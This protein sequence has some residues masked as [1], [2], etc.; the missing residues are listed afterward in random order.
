MVT[1]SPHIRT[2]EID[3]TVVILDLEQST[4]SVLNEAASAIWRRVTMTATSGVASSAPPQ[5]DQ[6]Q[7]TAAEFLE[8]CRR[9]RLLTDDPNTSLP[10]TPCTGWA[11]PRSPLALFLIGTTS[12]AIARGHFHTLYRRIALK[13]PAP[14]M[15]VDLNAAIRSFLVA[16]HFFPSSPDD[17]LPRSLSL[18]RYLTCLGVP[19]V[20]KIGVTLTPFTAHA[21]VEVGDAV[22]L[23]SPAF[24][25]LSLSN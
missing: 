14:V 15:R 10:R 3:G 11:G 5:S 23:D 18:F 4:Y 17:C 13:A 20:H 22:V 6:T 24:C 7:S 25:Q 16:E 2:A 1:I 8:Q 9:T 21:W 19:A 12:H